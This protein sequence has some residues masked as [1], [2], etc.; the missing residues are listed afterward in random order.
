MQR[1]YYS[2]IVL[3]LILIFIPMTGFNCE[4][5]HSIILTKVYLNNYSVCCYYHLLKISLINGIHYIQMYIQYAIQ[6]SYHHLQPVSTKS[7]TSPV[8]PDC[9]N[10]HSLD[11]PVPPSFRISPRWECHPAERYLVTSLLLLTRCPPQLLI[12]RYL[13]VSY[14]SGSQRLALDL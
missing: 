3:Y 4:G 5:N 6:S 9:F 1:K 11:S 8:S 13:K 14:V 2:H 12:F 7:Y 10:L